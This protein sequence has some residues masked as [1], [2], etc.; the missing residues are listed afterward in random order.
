[1]VSLHPI[2]ISLLEINYSVLIIGHLVF[3][4]SHLCTINIKC[5]SSLIIKYKKK[6]EKTNFFK[7]FKKRPEQNSIRYNSL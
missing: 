7:I 5:L 1:M 3:K 4:K 2:P 6:H